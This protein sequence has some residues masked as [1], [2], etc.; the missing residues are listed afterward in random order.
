MAIS[1]QLFEGQLIR[2][3]PI[4]HEKD[5]EIEFKVDA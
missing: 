5:A 2:L 1:T 3:A 4:D